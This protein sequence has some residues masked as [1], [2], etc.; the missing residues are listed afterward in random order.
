SEVVLRR[1]DD[2]PTNNVIMG[3]FPPALLNGRAQPDPLELRAGVTYRFRLINIRTDYAATVAV[4]DEGQP[5]QWRLVAKDGRA[6]P[7]WQATV[8][9]ASLTFAAGEI[10]DVE[11]TPQVGQDLTLQ[12]GG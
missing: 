4:L 7:A 1:S 11:F 5:A 2:G 6:L 3:P 12:F 8:R 10:Y 9:P